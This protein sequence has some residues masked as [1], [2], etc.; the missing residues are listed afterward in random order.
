MTNNSLD[1]PEALSELFLKASD[2]H[3][4]DTRYAS[5]LNFYRPR[6]R[7][8]FGKHTFKFALFKI[9]EEILVSLKHL[10][11]I[12]LSSIVNF[13]FWVSK[14]SLEHSKQL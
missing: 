5:N 8:N 4:Y 13:S 1:T 9:C 10:V 11:S 12:N 2:V 3:S 14:S 6:V 7:T